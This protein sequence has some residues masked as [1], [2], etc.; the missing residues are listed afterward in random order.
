MCLP[1]LGGCSDSQELS[2]TDFQLCPMGMEMTAA[3]HQC[4][5]DLPD[6]FAV[7]A[8]Y[9]FSDD[10]KMTVENPIQLRLMLPRQVQ[11]L[12]A[13]VVGVSMYMGRIPLIWQEATAEPADSN[14]S[15][16]ETRLLLGACSDPNMQWMIRLHIENSDGDRHTVLV[17]FQSSW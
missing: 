6:D 14:L 8:V 11:P 1:L 17:P 2:L 16:W 15:V 4:R 12:V 9:L 10:P 13:E 5:Y 3:Y 7:G